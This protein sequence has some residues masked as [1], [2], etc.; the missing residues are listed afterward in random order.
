[1]SLYQGIATNQNKERALLVGIRRPGQTRHDAEASLAELSRLV[2]TAGGEIIGSVSQ[3]IHSPHPATFIGKGKIE[4]I[5]ALVQRDGIQFV[6]I[7]DDLS[8]AQNRNLE[9][10]LK[11]KVL[12]RTAVILDICAKR[13]RT[14]EGRLQVELAQLQYLAPRLKGMWQH[15]GQQKGGIGMRGPGETQLEVD[16]RRIREKITH[17]RHQIEEVKTH[18]AVNRLKSEAVPLQLVSIVG[19]TNAGKSTLFNQLTRAQVLVE[20]QLFA[21]LDPTVRRLKL[22]SGRDILLADTV[23]FIRK[24]PHALVEA[25]KATFEEIAHAQLL[26]HVIDAA[27]PEASQQAEVVQTVL[28]ELEL[29]HKPMITV[30]NK[31]DSV[32]TPLF[33]LKGLSISALNGEGVLPLLEELDRVLRRDFMP[34]T[35]LLPHQRGDLLSQIYTLGHVESVTYLPE[36]IWVACQLHRKYFNKLKEFQLD[37]NRS[38]IPPVG[39][40]HLEGG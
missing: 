24:L 30:L 2:H 17:V 31:R 20:D 16:R 8:P 1:M 9:T 27:D 7:D 11:V 26:I 21:T 35:L 38:A 19:Y 4:E 22:P 29:D 5:L 10:T 28:Q 15:F 25:F 40:R 6:A 3:E 13:A 23:G 32:T 14:K 34:L 33:G 37:P 36:G 39:V 18:R 12:D